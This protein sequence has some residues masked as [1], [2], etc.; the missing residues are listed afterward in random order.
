MIAVCFTKYIMIKPTKLHTFTDPFVSAASGLVLMNDQFYLIADDELHA[1]V[2]DRKDL[3]SG[4]TITLFPVP[5]RKK[6]SS[7]NKRNRISNPSSNSRLVIF[8]AFLQ[9]LKNIAVKGSS[10]WPEAQK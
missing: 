4:K 1:V 3:S 7:G 2:V 6:R 5:W 10:S 8:F 9:A